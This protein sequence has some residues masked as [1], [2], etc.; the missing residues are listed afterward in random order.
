[1]KFKNILGKITFNA[2][3][4]S[5]EIFIISGI[6]GVVGSTIL[7]CRATMKINDVINESDSDI[8]KIKGYVAEND[9]SDEYTKQDEKKDLTIVYARTA[10]KIVKLY[11]P[12]IIIGSLSIAG[13]ISSNRI[14]KRRNIALASAYAAIDS[15]FASYRK[16]VIEKFGQETDEDLRFGV[17]EKKIETTEID[18]KTG[19]EKKVEKKV[20]VYD[21]NLTSDFATYF[22][23]KSKGYNGV[24]D[25]DL[26]FIKSQEEFA[27]NILHTRGYVF[28]NEVYD[29]LGLPFTKAGQVVGWRDDPKDSESDSYIDLRAH[30]VYREDENGK[31]E[32]VILIDPNVDGNILD[33]A[34]F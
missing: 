3:K 13:I 20:K 26:Y 18:P 31:L 19:K 17:K 23:N 9:Y 21:P 32:E 28:L 16:N 30:I 6:I 8:K 33:K 27:N 2:K 7:A 22:D 1:M 34:K 29:A 11:A 25:Y 24:I 10:F 14:L 4:H 15:S 12:A 5:P